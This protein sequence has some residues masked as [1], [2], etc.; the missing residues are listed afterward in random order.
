MLGCKAAGRVGAE[1]TRTGA[2][3][4]SRCSTGPP[5]EARRGEATHPARA[6]E[7]RTAP[8][9]GARTAQENNAEHSTRGRESVGPAAR[10]GA[11]KIRR[12]C[13]EAEKHRSQKIV[14]CV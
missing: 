8:A 6:E 10:R 5:E 13:D 12:N 1:G 9:A 4:S 2:R 11:E 14:N 7:E 3:T